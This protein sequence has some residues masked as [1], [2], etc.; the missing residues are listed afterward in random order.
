MSAIVDVTEPPPRWR[1]RAP[2]RSHSEAG[3]AAK[4][5]LPTPQGPFY[6]VLRLYQPREEVLKGEYQL[7]EVVKDRQAA[8]CQDCKCSREVCFRAGEFS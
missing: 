3:N 6:L 8:R 1:V 5:W 4:T 2:S 7:P